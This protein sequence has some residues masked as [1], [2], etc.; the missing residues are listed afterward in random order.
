MTIS[1]DVLYTRRSIRKFR[2]EPVPEDLIRRM[3]TAAHAAPS[4]HNARP[5]RFVVLREEKARRGLA[6]AMAAAYAW[7]AEAD[8]V[9][10]EKIR[11]R[12]ERSIGRIAGAPLA[13]LACMDEARLPSNAGRGEAGERLLL[14]QS[15]AAAVENLL[16]AAAEEK[17]GA[18][19][20]CAP[21][22]CPSAVAES[23]ALPTSWIAQAL[24]LIGLPAEVPLKPN[25]DS[26]E[27][28][29]QWR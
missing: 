11:V 12:N 26:L 25:G 4:A 3:L 24:I 1:M 19:W 28:V 21:A 23:L 7:D 22:F 14:T 5:W 16:L 17:L 6:E 2:S 20:L 27:E 9:E 18:C 8:G 29:V 10:A 13:V 15:V